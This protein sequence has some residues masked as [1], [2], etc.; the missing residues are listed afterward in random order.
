MSITAWEL[1]HSADLVQPK[2]GPLVGVETKAVSIAAA[3]GVN[4]HHVSLDAFSHDFQM[5]A[6]GDLLDKY[7]LLGH[8]MF[9]TNSHRL[10]SEQTKQSNCFKA[11]W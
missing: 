6:V 7:K 8:K 5:S 10:R 3:R 2:G 11:N 9:K 1:D 4:G